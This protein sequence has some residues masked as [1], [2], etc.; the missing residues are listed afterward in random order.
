MPRKL[1]IYLAAPPG[2]GLRTA[3]D[4]FREY[5]KPVL[6]AS[7]LDWEFRQGRQQG[8]IRA[9]V[10]EEVRKRRRRAEGEEEV[11]DEADLATTEEHIEQWRREHGIAEYDGVRGDIVI[12]RHTW[13]EYL[14]GL[15]EGWLGPLRTPPH[16]QPDP[17]PEV[18]EGEEQEKRPKRPAQPK[19]YNSI[20]DYATAHLPR[21]I[22]DELAPSTAIPFPHILGFLNTPIRTYRYLTR[23]RLADD[24]GREVAAA[25]L[26]TYRDY[27]ELGDANSEQKWEQQAA[28]NHEEGNWVKS[29]WK[30]DE[31]AAQEK[32]TKSADASPTAEGSELVDESPQ[33]AVVKKE[34]IWPN[35]VVLD[36][37]IAMRMRRFE[38]QP[39][40]EQR[41]RNVVVPEEEIEGAIKGSLRSLW[42]WGAGAFE[43][44]EKIPNVGEVD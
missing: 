32:K 36:P 40:D 12:G 30:P 22:P 13:K 34:K 16:A 24:I 15:H 25:C 38:I 35:P 31:E 17:E 33:P 3:Q 4:H 37:R 14:R 9:V 23:R 43:K 29:V 27:K 28:L 7:G 42:R 6:A 18:V 10:A 39:E 8:D 11:V 5:V 26:C 19:P 44:K 21:T 20:E 41:A 2:D 1:T